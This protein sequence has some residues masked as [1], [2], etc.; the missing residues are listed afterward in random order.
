VLAEDGPEAVRLRDLARRIGASH[1]APAHHFGD[2]TGLLTAIAAEGFTLLAE[3]LDEV[4]RRTGDL[5]EV[6]V[7]YVRFGVEHRA[8]FEVMF[9][10]DLYRQDD[11]EV[12]LTR[13]RA[14]EH[15]APA[16][17]PTHAQ[18]DVASIAAWCLVHGFTTLWNSGNL[19]PELGT[20]PSTLART[21][22]AEGPQV[23]SD[24]R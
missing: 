18:S 13:Q 5:I 8:H 11:P 19:P 21:I 9:R 10:P 17:A 6:G 4:W 23:Q 2:R 15:C 24:R 1:V 12:R 22:L 3:A 14:G 16:P 20:N 7:A